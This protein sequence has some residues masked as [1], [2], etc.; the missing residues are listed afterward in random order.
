MHWNILMFGLICSTLGWT[1]H[2][3]HSPL[4]TVMPTSL[5]ANRRDCRGPALR[6]ATDRRQPSQHAV[7]RG[8]SSSCARW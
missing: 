7:R 2:A 3:A 1:A 8:I 5:L 6:S 4:P